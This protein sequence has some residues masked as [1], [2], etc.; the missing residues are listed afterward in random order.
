MINNVKSIVSF[1]SVR[2]RGIW[3]AKFSVAFQRTK[4]IDWLSPINFFL[5][6]AEIIA[7]RQPGTGSWL[8]ADRRYC[9]WEAGSG[10]ILWCRGIPGAGK[11]VLASMVVEHLGAHAHKKNIGVACLYLKHR[12]TDM[13]MP[14]DLLSSLWRQLV[15][16]KPITS[17]VQALYLQHFE[18]QTRPSLLEV[19][20]VLRSAIRK[21]T[22]VYIV[23]D[24]FDEYPEYPRHVL[25]EALAA[26]G[27]TVNL[28][29]TSRPHIDLNVSVP[30]LETMEIR[31]HAE[32]IHKYVDEQI[33]RSSRLLKHL[34][35]RPELLQEIHSKILSSVDGMCLHMDSLSTKNTIKTAR[36]ALNNLPKDLG[37]SY[38]A[39]MTR[40]ADQN[41]DDKKMAHL[42]LTWI[43]NAKKL[44]TIPQLQEALAIEPGSTS[45]DQD[46][47]VDIDT[48]LAACAGLIILDENF[49]VVRLVHYTAQHYL[50]SVQASRFPDAQ[51]VIT[52]SLL[53]FLAFDGFA[54]SSEPGKTYKPALLEYGQYCLLHARGHPEERC[55][56]MIID[57]LE[58]AS[59]WRDFS[60]VNLPGGEYGSA[61]HAASYEG[62]GDIVQLLIDNGADVNLEAGE[63]G[64]ALQGAS[65]S[66]HA[67]IVRLL[68][69]KGASIN[70]QNG[71][72]GSA[73][74]A[75]SYEGHE[76]IVHLLLN[77]GADVMM[78]G[79]RFGT[80]LQ[81]AAGR[82]HKHV[83]RMLIEAGADVNTNGG[84]FGSALQAA[85]DSGHE[86]VV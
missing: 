32:D 58:R 49:H 45:F 31:A 23:V 77:A 33:R 54:H 13:Q 80:A 37:H 34:K 9:L 21:W 25:M 51:I 4:I 35:A 18:K 62:E 36:E 78:Q 70:T 81:A 6:Q 46:D 79:G 76:D 73:L 72:Y 17:L 75:A 53:T 61:L 83:A 16:R 48:I 86:A 67:G 3:D 1:K 44:L 82:G 63:L 65:C 55:T 22:K 66:G 60:D 11:T 19:Q 71:E 52:R 56:D 27:P 57:F 10:R 29:V 74:H 39:A 7:A 68:I 12:E 2:S 64:T 15:L 85:A 38:D 43:A 59:Q 30:N 40:I 5:Q 14:L 20:E 8:L 50:D 69:Q 42:A 84:R 26:L 47:L 41:E 24:A 28:L